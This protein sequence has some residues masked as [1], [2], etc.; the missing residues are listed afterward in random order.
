[1]AVSFSESSISIANNTS[2]IN[3]S[4]SI[5][6]PSSAN[7]ESNYTSYLKI[8]W[9]DNCTGKETLVNST[10]FSSIAL[11]GTRSV[12][13]SITV[14][15][16]SNG[17]LSGYAKVTFT[18]GSNSGGWCP[19]SNNVATANTALT[20]I[21]RASSFGTISGST[22]GSEITV[23]IT[24]ADSSFTHQLWYKDQTGGWFDCGSGI[25]T[26]IS[27]TP[28]LE[29]CNLYPNSTSGTLE[30]CLRT[31]SGTSQIGSDVYKNITVY[32]PS[33]V[34]PSISSVTATR[35]DG[36]VPAAWGVY[37][38]GYSKATIKINGASGKYGS[39]I[40]SYSITGGGLSSS[41]SSATSGFLSS[42]IAFTGKVTD[43]RGRT[44]SKIVYVD[45][46]DYFPPSISVSA[47][48][49]DSAGNITSSG[50][51]LKVTC[52][53]NYASVSEKNAITRSV[54]CNNVSNTSFT[55]GTSFILAANCS[56]G[57]TFVLTAKITDTLGKTASATA[58]IPTDSRIMNIK[59]NGKAIAFGMF[60]TEDNTL[61]SAWDIY[62]PHLHATANGQDLNI[63][64]SD[65]QWCNYY[66]TSSKHW[67]NK[68]VYVQGD[69]YGGASY[70]RRLAY[71]DEFAP[72]IKG[73]YTGSG[74]YHPPNYFKVGGYLQMMNSLPSGSGYYDCLVLHS[75]ISDVPICNM[76]ALGKNSDSRIKHYRQNA[77][78]SVWTY[79][80]TLAYTSEVDKKGKMVQ[81]GKTTSN[82]YVSFTTEAL[83][84]FNQIILVCAARIDTNAYRTIATSVMP[85]S[86]FISYCT[87]DAKTMMACWGEEPKN[88][89]A[90]L[91]KSTTTTET[92]IKLKC[93]SGWDMALAFGVR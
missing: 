46:V 30:L 13:G 40:R 68:P 53:Y 50:T 81:L 72:A 75:Y 71:T 77:N 32:V 2:V 90:Q 85:M 21:A 64:S 42:S 59:K 38:K 62:A 17:S 33:S 67:F 39:S 54:T 48:R 1:M 41:S 3:V 19:G 10:S 12:S 31:Y 80:G 29:V 22:I 91:Y 9:F 34:V 52:N 23:N 78:D 66:T 51:Y 60:A 93:I 45:V 7:W 76:L 88:Y 15:H 58:T 83:S 5:K 63:G 18:A 26:S 37:V 84:N 73:V 55:N 44:A 6:A 14:K 89:K 87:S 24:R 28:S 86:D 43:S 25:A 70:N 74:G 47:K 36:N 69:V 92:T 11:S 4:G 82:T 8:Y 79:K 49:C 61:K 57:S 35:V 56:I 27:F 16:N 20:T 65:A